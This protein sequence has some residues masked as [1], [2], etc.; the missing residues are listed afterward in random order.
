MENITPYPFYFCCYSELLFI[1]FVTLGTGLGFRHDF[2]PPVTLGLIRSQVMIVEIIR[3]T[4][5][6]DAE[7]NSA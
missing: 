4:F 7:L 2:T 6:P 3:T 1:F 5:P